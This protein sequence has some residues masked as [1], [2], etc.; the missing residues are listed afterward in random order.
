MPNYC[1]HLGRP[2]PNGD[3][4][5]IGGKILLRDGRHIGLNVMMFL[6]ASGGIA[7]AVDGDR[8]ARDLAYA[9]QHQSAEKSRGLPSQ[10]SFSNG[11]ALRDAALAARYS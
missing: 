10:M 8:V 9:R 3:Y 11:R 1:D 5:I 4:E 6:D 2:D 7:P